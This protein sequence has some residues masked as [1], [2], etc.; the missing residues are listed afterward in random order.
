MIIVF[1]LNVMLVNRESKTLK[2][3]SCFCG[4]V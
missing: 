4:Y 2:G 3:V 1:I